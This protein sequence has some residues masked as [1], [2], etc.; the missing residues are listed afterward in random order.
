MVNAS[1]R[2]EI[3]LET[4][5]KTVVSTSNVSAES[6]W[7]PVLT[8][9]NTGDAIETVTVLKGDVEVNHGLLAHHAVIEDDVN[10]F[11]RSNSHDSRASNVGDG[12]VGIGSIE[13]IRL[14]TAVARNSD[15][16]WG[17]EGVNK[18]EENIRN[19]V[20]VCLGGGHSI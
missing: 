3:V 6:A 16:D 12:G 2:E 8:T 11:L 5:R 1:Q 14:E 13:E 7:A 19:I 18:V 17:S 10:A 9:E 15:I 20:R 4:L